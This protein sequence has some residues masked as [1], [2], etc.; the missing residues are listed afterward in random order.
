M[1]KS[2]FKVVIS[3]EILNNGKTEDFKSE[4]MYC[5]TKCKGDA[6]PVQVLAIL[7]EAARYIFKEHEIDFESV[8]ADLITSTNMIKLDKLCNELDKIDMFLDDNKKEK[9]NEKRNSTK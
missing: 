4:M 3:A 5:K 1:D 9:K 7:V 8:L 2:K 6:T